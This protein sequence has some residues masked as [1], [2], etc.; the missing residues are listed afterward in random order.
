[1]AGD[2][3]VGMPSGGDQGQRTG[4]ADWG[5]IGWEEGS[6]YKKSKVD[7]RS[8]EEKELGISAIHL[9]GKGAERHGVKLEHRIL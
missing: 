2:Q 5:E 6:L 4:N 7:I 8:G 1:M 3:C 9:M